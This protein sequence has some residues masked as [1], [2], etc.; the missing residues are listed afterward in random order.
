[1]K[2]SHFVANSNPKKRQEKT[3]DQDT[4]F[5]RRKEAP[6]HD[7][8]PQLGSIDELVP[9]FITLAK[10]FHSFRLTAHLH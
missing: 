3:N 8:F 10:N 6:P 7:A 4:G 2:P 5:G 9:V 1:M